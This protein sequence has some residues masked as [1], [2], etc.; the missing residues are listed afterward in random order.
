MGALLNE[1]DLPRIDTLP[2][3]DYIWHLLHSSPPEL[4]TEREDQEK[5][6]EE[7]ERY[8]YLRFAYIQ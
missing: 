4:Q 8:L 6:E 3:V 7:R 5:K 1:T 2:H